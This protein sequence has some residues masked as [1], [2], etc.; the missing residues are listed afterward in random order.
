MR[1]PERWEIASAAP[2]FGRSVLI[3]LAFAVCLLPSTAVAQ[4]T[5]DQV[6]KERVVPAKEEIQDRVEKS[7]WHLGPF[8]LLPILEISQL[9][10]DSNVFGIP[11]TTGAGT[12]EPIS[13][14]IA[15]VTLGVSGISRL[16]SKMYL[17]ADA[18]PEYTWYQKLTDRRRFG[19]VYDATWYGFFNRM[20]FYVS[21][22]AL[23]RTTILNSETEAP[24]HRTSRNGSAGLEVD[25]ARPLAVFAWAAVATERY[26]SDPA[27]PPELE[28]PHQLDR[29]D[30]AGRVGLR[31]KFR[32]DYNVAAAVEGTRTDFVSQPEQGNNKSV[33]YLLALYYNRPRF[34]LNVTG[35]YRDARPDGG[36]TFPGFR[37]GTG[38]FFASY[39]LRPRLELQVYGHRAPAYGLTVSNPYYFDNLVGSGLNVGIGQRVAVQGF[40]EYGENRYPTPVQTNTGVFV[41]RR[42]QL[43]NVG[44]GISYTF[45][46]R[47]TVRATASHN[48]HDSNIPDFTR[49]VFR[50]TTALTFTGDFRK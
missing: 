28:D 17:R 10:Y 48:R 31:L 8:Y 16:G 9:G 42:D 43:T 15:D 1:T 5:S 29:T 4:L 23:S 50:F 40:Y 19:G 25:V 18:L 27:L 37:T 3:P 38:S 39:F 2:V 35:G 36:S 32:D 22:T 20:S 30:T 45:F 49:S 46:R 11:E 26:S 33:A 14:W 34:F 6:P 13:D 44:G 7:R 41:L 21:G 12:Q 24:I 47:A